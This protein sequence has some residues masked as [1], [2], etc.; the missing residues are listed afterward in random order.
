MA[1]FESGIVYQ[2]FSGSKV[3]ETIQTTFD[4]LFRT[5]NL[6]LAVDTLIEA[7]VA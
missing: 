4:E 7:P 1:Y 2:L 6:T 3:A 5:K